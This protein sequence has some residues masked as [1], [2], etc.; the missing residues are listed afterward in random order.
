MLNLRHRACQVAILRVAANHHPPAGIL[1]IDGVRPHSS[2]DVSEFAQ[3]DLSPV[4]RQ[5]DP[6][7]L[8]VRVKICGVT[9]VADAEAAVVHGADALGLNF[10]PPSARFLEAKDAIAI[11]DTVGPFVSL[12]ALFVD[13]SAGDVKRVVDRVTVQLLQFHGDE[14]AE[15]CEQFSLPYIK[16]VKVAAPVDQTESAI[17]AVQQQIIHAAQAHPRAKAILL[18]TLTP[19]EHGGTGKQFDW[20]CVPQSKHFRWILAGGLR[21]DNVANAVAQVNPYAVD[22]SS[23]VES[24]PGVKDPEKL[25]AF[26]GAAKANR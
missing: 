18:D 22:V 26:I 17:S 2:T 8:Q 24:E 11:A 4:V 19:G 6:Q 21:P 20:R 3:L 25:A 13:A 9:S 10:Y 14:P 1:P 16:A 7:S 23:G 5:I 15:F 12:V